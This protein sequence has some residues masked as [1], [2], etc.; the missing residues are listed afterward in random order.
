MHCY[1]GNLIEKIT[2]HLLNFF[3]IEKLTVKRDNQDGPLKKDLKKFDEGK[4]VRDIE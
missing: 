4:L 3:I 2:D 1:R